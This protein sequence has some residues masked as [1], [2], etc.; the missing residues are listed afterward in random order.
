MANIQRY[1]YGGMLDDVFGDLMKGFW[2]KPEPK[3]AEAV[4]EG[5]SR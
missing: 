1:G 2:V 5:R 4:G 3:E